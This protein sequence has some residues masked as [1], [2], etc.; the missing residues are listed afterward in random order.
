MT[1]SKCILWFSV[2]WHGRGGFCFAAVC[3]WHSMLGNWHSRGTGFVPFVLHSIVFKTLPVLFTNVGKV[4]ISLVKVQIVCGMFSF[5]GAP[6]GNSS[7]WEDYIRSQKRRIPPSVLWIR[8]S[9]SQ[10]KQV[11]PRPGGGGGGGCYS[12]IFP[13]RDVPPDRVPFSGSSV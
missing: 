9:L 3:A 8:E 13:H 2:L 10:T 6:R 4:C 7:V 12:H 11:S 1:L 5:A